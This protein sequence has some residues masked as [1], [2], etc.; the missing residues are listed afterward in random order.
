MM[1]RIPVIALTA[2]C[3]ELIAAPAVAQTPPTYAD[4]API[5]AENCV[6]CHGGP[7]AVLGLRLDSLDGLRRGSRNGPVAV[8]GQPG[9]SELVRRIR[10]ISEPRM[11]LTGPPFLDDGQITLIE[12]WVAAGMPEGQAAAPQADATPP[13]HVPMPGEPVMWGDIAPIL[14]KH[15]VKCHTDNGLIAGGPPEGLRLKSL[16]SVLA[17]GER[18]VVVPRNPGVSELVRRVRGLSQPRMPL[19]GPPYLSGEEIRLIMDWVAW[20]A[21]NDAGNTAPI[22]VGAAV[23]F[24]GLLTAR[25]EVDGAP[26]TVTSGTRIDKNPQVGD[27][28]EVRGRVTPDGSLSVERIRRR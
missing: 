4:I 11:P 7:D 26:V 18:I 15:C 20:G 1:P 13:R 19:D 24:E 16:D 27:Y 5:L 9:G 22:P 17:G 25:W 23:R 2:L 12:A 8:P 3:L 6:G 21:L 10:G 14:L 28:V